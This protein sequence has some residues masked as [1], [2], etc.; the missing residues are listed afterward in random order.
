MKLHLTA[1]IN[2]T[3]D[4]SGALDPKVI[5]LHEKLKLL[6]EQLDR[7]QKKLD[8]VAVTELDNILPKLDTDELIRNVKRVNQELDEQIAIKK[9]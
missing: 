3:A 1:R 4:E 2:K 7:I 9:K 6:E 8:T 5:E